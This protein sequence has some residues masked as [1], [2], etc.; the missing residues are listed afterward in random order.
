MKIIG[1]NKYK[2]TVLGTNNSSMKVYMELQC[3]YSNYS[4]DNY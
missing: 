2:R 3:K 4:R 1:S